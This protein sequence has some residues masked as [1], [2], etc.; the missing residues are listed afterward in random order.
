MRSPPS[1]S[2][3]LI[4]MPGVSIGTTN[5]VRP[6][7]FGTSAL[8]RVRSSTYADSCAMVVNIFWPLTIQ[9]SPS[10]TARVDAAAMSDPE[11]GSE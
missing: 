6:R 11:S 1:V 10:R 4:S 5:M 9:S 8:V 2:I 3:G 7:C